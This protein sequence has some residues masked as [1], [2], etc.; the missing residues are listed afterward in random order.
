MI[1]FNSKLPYYY[2]LKDYLIEQI[3]KG[4][5]KQGEKI[6]S[7]NELVQM[8][9]ISRPTVRQA[10]NEMMQ[11]GYLVKKRG[12]GTF[13]AN[14]VYTGNANTFTTFAEEMTATGHN[15]MAKL[16]RAEM[17]EASEKV[18][19]EL[20]IEVSSSVF[21]ITR[22]R[23]ANEEPLVIRTSIIPSH[24]YPNLLDEDL[25]SIPLYET[26][27][28]RGLSPT[29]SKQTFQAVAATEEEA[30]LLNVEI[31]APLILWKGIVYGEQDMPIEMVRALYLGSRFRFTVD[32]T[33][34]MLL[35]G[36]HPDEGWNHFTTLDF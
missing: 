31:G 22:L 7:E 32:Q 30:K 3:E 35:E 15:H 24:L 17:I 28:K 13:V 11:E 27:E 10:L 8:C 26:M 23:L 1:I 16:V 34:N 5:Y 20:N 19:S 25:E 33:R 29:R 9:G 21:E 12:I 14:H 2:Q 4:I 6:P 36:N 18:A